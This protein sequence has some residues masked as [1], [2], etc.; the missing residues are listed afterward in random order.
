MGSRGRAEIGEKTDSVVVEC[1]DISAAPSRRPSFKPIVSI[2]TRTPTFRPDAETVQVHGAVSGLVEGVYVRLEEYMSEQQISID[3]HEPQFFFTVGD[4]EPYAIGIEV[5][6]VGYFCRVIENGSGRARV[7]TSPK[8]VN[9]ECEKM[10]IPSITPTTKRPT[11][12][13][14][15]QT[16]IL[17]GKVEGL[18]EGIYAEI[19]E[20]K[21]SERIVGTSIDPNFIFEIHDEQSYNIIVSYQPEGM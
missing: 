15:S 16:V 13:P 4:N 9:V 5:Q 19:M 10:V 8:S 20:T 12:S 3:P 14:N 21:T 2:T 1:V 11:F 7:G 17:Q 6:P 18:E